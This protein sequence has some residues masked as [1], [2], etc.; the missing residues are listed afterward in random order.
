MKDMKAIFRFVLPGMFAALV[1]VSTLSQVVTTN[2]VGYVNTTLLPG[3]NLITNPLYEEGYTVADLVRS[4]QGGAPEGLRIYLLQTNSYRSAAYE[5]ASTGFQP[6]EVA[7]EPLT[8]GRGFFIYNP[9]TN[10]LTLTFTGQIMNGQLDIPLAEGFSMVASMVPQNGTPEA[11]EFPSE[12]GDIIY[13]F[14]AVNQRFKVFV[15]DYF[16]GR[17]LPNAPQIQTGEGYIVY[18]DQATVWSRF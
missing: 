10:H 8:P 15:F 5:S 14:D 18:K 13:Q 12:P 2:A 9:R 17:W 16:D 3:F 7:S 4:I 1:Q 11:L 6:G